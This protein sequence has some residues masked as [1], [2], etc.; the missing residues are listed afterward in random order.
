[1]PRPAND[2]APA[3]EPG[4]RALLPLAFDH[5]RIVTDGPDR[6]R[7]KI[8][9]TPSAPAFLVEEFTI[10]DLRGIYASIWGSPLHAGNFHRKVRSV[11][12]F[13]ESTGATVARGEARGCP[14]PALPCGRRATAAPG[15]AAPRDRERCPYDSG[16]PARPRRRARPRRPASRSRRAHRAGR[17]PPAHGPLPR[18]PH[19]SRPDLPHAPE[20]RIRDLPESPRSHHAPPVALSASGREGTCMDERDGQVRRQRAIHKEGISNCGRL[21]RSQPLQ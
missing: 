7:T 14:R 3:T 1:M 6:A 10:A 9:Y 2:P 8:E 4:P 12:G 15:A 20:W 5:A 19:R 21:A 11:T 17:G 18:R 13:V 16:R